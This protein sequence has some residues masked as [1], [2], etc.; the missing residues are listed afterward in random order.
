M[1]DALA[2]AV[3]PDTATHSG[4]RD[5]DSAATRH[6]CAGV[7]VDRS[8]RELVIRRIHNDARH[9]I[10]P[11]YGFDL[12][13]VVRHAWRSWLLET[14]QLL[15]I[16]CTLI[17]GLLAGGLLATVIVVSAVVFWSLLRGIIREIPAVF[18]EIAR[19]IA[20]RVGRP[21]KT[22][23][24]RSD[25]SNPQNTK[26]HLKAMSFCL[27]VVIAA[28]FSTALFLDSPIGA[29]L[30]PAAVISC[31][32]LVCALATG[33]VRQALLNAL[34]KATTTRPHKLTRRE[35]TIDEQQDHPCVIYRRPPHRDG[36]I[37]PLE[38]LTRPDTPSPFV[39]SGKLV[40][41]WLPPLTIQL[42]RPGDGSLD[43]RE[44]TSPPFAA[45]QLVEAL[46][47]ALKKLDADTGGESLPGLR[48]RDRIYI[49]ATDFPADSRLARTGL[50]KLEI[51]QIIDNHTLTG[52]HF[53]ETSVPIAGGELV[54]TV[55]IRVSLKGRSL[56]LD[57]ATCA[58]TRTR[59]A[60]HSIDWFGESGIG[61]LV[62]S[63]ARSLAAAPG[64]VLRIWRLLETPTVAV[65][66][67]LAQ[68]DQTSLP[69]RRSV[70]PTVAVREEIADSWD[71]SQLDRAT[72]YDHMKIVEQR[73]LK[74]TE[75]FLK[76]H[77]VDT[78]VFDKQAMNI[79]NSGV[80]NMGG[81]QMT[82]GDL[83][84]GMGAQIIKNGNANGAGDGASA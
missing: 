4:Y 11:S 78:S 17:V 68:R 60:Y 5:A 83:A 65:R 75:D 49:A 7:Y 66:A 44:Y 64:D 13:P 35:S 84:A 82:V 67:W 25:E 81:S 74:A 30:M 22:E 41:R 21:R 6:M 9:R 10:A 20:K 59:D 58:L 15:A 55:L 73:I 48:V 12:V 77:G 46:H 2:A 52:H 76:K 72:I 23:R 57:V 40:N 38:L 79:I 14:G 8:F 69:R 51:W 31:V 45:H 37:D 39:G 62:R 50:G 18:Q 42:L 54:A 56:S 19:T 36:D 61:G 70:G 33:T 34:A 16:L 32:I 43:E 80:L 1:N 28:P 3:P 47:V 63:A 71:N 29:A 53:L 26:R 27:L 24:G